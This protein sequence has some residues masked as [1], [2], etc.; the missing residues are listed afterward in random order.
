[1]GYATALGVFGAFAGLVFLGVIKLG[2]RWS[3]HS[4]PGWFD[5]HWWWVGVTADVGPLQTFPILN[6]VVT[7][8]LGVEAAKYALARR[9]QERSRGASG[10]ET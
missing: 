5:G 1:M 4:S 7:S 3:T 6:A 8:F 10:P 9:R 2:S